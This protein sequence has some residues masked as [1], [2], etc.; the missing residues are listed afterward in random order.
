M[1]LL[2]LFEEDLSDPAK[3]ETPRSKNIMEDIYSPISDADTADWLAE[4]MIDF[5]STWT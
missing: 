5:F 1:P 3:P 4:L 2:Y